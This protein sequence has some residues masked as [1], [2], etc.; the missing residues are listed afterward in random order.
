M[1]IQAGWLKVL[2]IF[3]INLN[4]LHL[5]MF[6]LKFDWYWPSGSGDEKFININLF[7][8]FHYHS[9]LEMNMTLHLHKLEFPIPYDALCQ[10]WLKLEEWFYRGFRFLNIVD[11]FLVCHNYLLLERD[12]ALQLKK[13]E[14]LYLRMC[15]AK[16]GWNWPSGS[17]EYLKNVFLLFSTL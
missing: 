7:S 5:W 9:L 2:N 10:V 15:C 14:F 1:I 12:K 16:F 11:A 3:I 4:F 6:C 13:L 17:W 8:P